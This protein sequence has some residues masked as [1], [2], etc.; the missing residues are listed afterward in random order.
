MNVTL[1]IGVIVVSAV[2]AWTGDVIGKR[3]GKK[4][5]SLFGLRPRQTAVLIAV[6]TGWVITLSTMAALAAAS[7]DVRE[8][9]FNL[10]RLHQQVR[11]AQEEAAGAL[12]ALVE[13]RASLE[14]ANAERS[15]AESLASMA[16]A[17]AEAAR[18]QADRV[19]GELDKA[20]GEVADLRSNRDQLEGS[21]VGLTAE[22]TKAR[23]ARDR[24]LAEAGKVA[25][26]GT[27]YLYGYGMVHSENYVLQPGDE[28]ARTIVPAHT[29]VE[30]ARSR[31]EQ[32]C[33]DGEAAARNA[34][35]APYDYPD[36]DIDATT[37][38]VLILRRA[39]PQSGPG[40]KQLALAERQAA[41]AS[42]LDSVAREASRRSEGGDSVY[43]TLD[44]GESATPSRRPAIV[45]FRM[46]RVVP[47][48]RRGDVLATADVE[49]GASADAVA[50]TCHRLL[51]EAR[52]KAVDR[53]TVWRRASDRGIPYN[54]LESAIAEVLRLQR[55]MHLGARLAAIVQQECLNIDEPDIRI[56]VDPVF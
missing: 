9:I 33:R 26:S 4:R 28:L 56:E 8:A 45:E 18:G 36:D 20:S 31:I 29:S 39:E 11:D 38:L 30:A 25:F 13:T 3:L 37:G 53:G 55:D 52:A 49:A 35:C 40:W 32:L 15:A 19:Q 44:V 34:G 51:R 21:I 24:A 41:Y 6:F 42:Y 22:G 12:A 5:V 2:V 7:R 54:Q 17:S 14:E 10:D 1:V 47:V 23:D 46:D 43:V 50:E 27:L 48:L 16:E